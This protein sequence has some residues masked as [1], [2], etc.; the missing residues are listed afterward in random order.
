MNKIDRYIIKKF[1]VTFFYS[2]LLLLLIVIVIDFSE[3]IDDFIQS[4]LSFFTIMSEYYLHFIPYF[5]NLFSPLFIFISVVFF[6]S[7]LADNSEIIA[8]FN[9]GMSFKR[10]LR[11]FIISAVFLSVLSFILGSYVI[12]ISNKYRIDFENKY[13]KKQKKKLAK[14]IHLQKTKN[15]YYYLHQYNHK[16]NIGYKFSIENFENGKL[17]NKLRSEYIQWNEETKKWTLNKYEIR[18]FHENGET[19]T[20][21][22]K[23]RKTTDTT[24]MLLPSDFI[25]QP[26][27]AE[28]MNLNELNKNIESETIKSSGKSKFYKIEKHKRIAFPFAIII[29]TIIAVS[30]SSK[31]KKSGIG[32]NMG[33][34]LLISFSYILFFQ[35]SSTLSINGNLEPWIAV[36][37]PNILYVFLGILLL[38][39]TQNI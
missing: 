30:L 36:W 3:K 29:L 12:P 28:T 9:S 19:I 24:L 13:I 6:T 18:T 14:G 2:L 22:K 4:N 17:K 23:L 31:K 33:L 20:P 7:R 15:H 25:V 38:R 5:A 21:S 10:F 11:P 16:R 35:F 37:I 8:I 1:L 32:T 27:L 39:K 34:G 26:N